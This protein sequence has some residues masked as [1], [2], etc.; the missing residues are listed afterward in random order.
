MKRLRTVLAL[1][2]RKV[3]MESCRVGI[4]VSGAKV[5]EFGNFAAQRGAKSAAHN[6]AC[7]T[8]QPAK[9]E[10]VAEP[11][12]R[13]AWSLQAVDGSLPEERDNRRSL[14]VDPQ[15]FRAVFGGQ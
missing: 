13:A 9:G 3:G 15:S 7:L 10:I 1:T 4:A 5:F 11:F 2:V 14:V 8:H 12:A 6:A